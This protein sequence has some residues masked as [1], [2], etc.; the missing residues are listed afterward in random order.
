MRRLWCLLLLP[1]LAGCV[2]DDGYQTPVA[3]APAYANSAGAPPVDQFLLHSLSPNQ[4]D[5]RLAGGLCANRGAAALTNGFTF[6]NIASLM[7]SA[8]PLLQ[9]AGINS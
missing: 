5:V 4:P 6:G 2:V 3:Y 1:T 8:T 9:L 7:T